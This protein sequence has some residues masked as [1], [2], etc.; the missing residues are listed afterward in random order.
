MFFID[1]AIKI[2]VLMSCVQLQC[3]CTNLKIGSLRF[4]KDVLLLK[5]LLRLGFCAFSFEASPNCYLT[6][7]VD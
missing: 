7:I 5:M 1:I 6:S 4:K 2:A 3:P